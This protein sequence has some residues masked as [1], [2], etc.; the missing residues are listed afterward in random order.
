MRKLTIKRTKSFVGC[1]MKVK[2][3]IEDANASDNVI[4]GVSCRLLGK[5]K[6]GEE[7]TFEIE[8]REAKVYVIFDNLSKSYCSEFYQL[9]E[10]EEDIFLSGKNYFNPLKGNPFRFD[11]ND[12]AEALENR[13]KNSSVGTV[14]FI[15]AIVVGAI[16]GA[17]VAQA[18]L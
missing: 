18:L 1:A 7:R 4:N 9:S 17:L 10:G 11:N 8:N 12:N 6:S 13:K 16:V 3:Y 2:V 14:I 5:I 15:T